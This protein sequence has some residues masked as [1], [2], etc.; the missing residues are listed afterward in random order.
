VLARGGTYYLDEPLVFGAQEAPAT[1]AVYP[2]EL[3]TISGGRKLDCKWKPYKDSIVTCELPEVENGKLDI[4]R[5]VV[6][7]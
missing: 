1:Y 7:L 5:R 4:K 2:G 3:V 6:T